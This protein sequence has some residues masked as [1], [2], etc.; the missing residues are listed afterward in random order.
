MHTLRW[1]RWM[2]QKK[3][4]KSFLSSFL[5]YHLAVFS[6]VNVSL[7]IEW[8]KKLVQLMISWL[9]NIFSAVQPAAVIAPKFIKL[10]NSPIFRIN[11]LL[12]LEAIFCFLFIRFTACISFCDVCDTGHYQT[13][14]K[15]LFITYLWFPCLCTPYLML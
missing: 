5:S 11:F 10:P 13:S 1:N 12:L 14:E 15:C 3:S 6:V 8:G 7:L 4:T 9:Q 2:L